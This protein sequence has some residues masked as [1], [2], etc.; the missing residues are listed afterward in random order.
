MS[1]EE[2]NQTSRSLGTHSMQAVQPT[3]ALAVQ[4]EPE[5]AIKIA[6]AVRGVRW[7]SGGGPFVGLV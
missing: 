6:N 3:A 1:K 4:P 2:L 7:T 5:P